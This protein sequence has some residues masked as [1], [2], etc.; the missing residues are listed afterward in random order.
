[1]S[2]EPRE[3]LRHIQLEATFLCSVTATLTYEHF[4]ADPTLQRAAVRCLE[5][6]GEAPSESRRKCVRHTPMSN[7]G[8]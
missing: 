3:Y 6:I 2:F 1:M 4:M 7:G 5:I 8:R